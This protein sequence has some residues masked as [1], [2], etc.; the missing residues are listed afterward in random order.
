MSKTTH[1]LSLTLLLLLAFACKKG[2]GPDPVTV[3]ETPR[4]ATLDLASGVPGNIVTA[5]FNFRLDKESGEITVGGH[6]TVF[7]KL[8][9]SSAVFMVPYIPSGDVKIE[10]G[11]LAVPATAAFKVKAYTAVSAPDPVKD[12]VVTVMNEIAADASLP[13]GFGGSMATI[14]ENFVSGYQKLTAAEKA[15]VAFLFEQAMLQTP[16]TPQ[17]RQ[18]GGIGNGQRLD[19]FKAPTSIESDQQYREVMLQCAGLYVLSLSNT[20]LAANMI[21]APTGV[22]QVAGLAL[23]GTAFYTHSQANKCRLLLLKYARDTKSVESAT[24]GSYVPSIKKEGRQS[25]ASAEKEGKM[26]FEKDI[27]YEIN[28]TAMHVSLAYGSKS[29]VILSFLKELKR[30]TDRLNSAINFINNIKSWFVKS[31]NI[32]QINIG[33]PATGVE[34]ALTVKAEHVT[35]ANISNPAIILTKT[36]KDGKLI[37]KASS[38]TVTSDTEF[39]VDFVFGQPFL[40][41]SNHVTVAAL[42]SPNL[43]PHSMSLVLGNNQYGEPGEQ[44]TYPLVVKVLDV[45]GQ[46]MKDVQVEWNVTQGAGR[47]T[48]AK[49]YT[50]PDGRAQIEWTLGEDETQQVQ[51][52]VKKKDG[53]PVTGSPVVFTATTGNPWVKMISGTIWKRET[54]YLYPTS[55]YTTAQAQT[56]MKANSSECTG[57]LST[58]TYNGVVYWNIKSPMHEDVTF[59]RNFNVTSMNYACHVNTPPYENGLGNWDA[60]IDGYLKIR[61]AD[62]DFLYTKLQSIDQ[63]EIMV[64]KTVSGGQVNYERWTLK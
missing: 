24:M 26:I 21:A 12:R 2:K 57:A 16:P 47:V 20:I 43:V 10:F 33:I 64:Y 35:L 42:Y 46:P 34:S 60:S 11:V 48:A 31:P 53:T 45:R 52:V 1:L 62:F 56:M 41:L 30:V 38:T 58:M 37:I 40:G 22:T 13:E 9:D 28:V 59:H 14:R 8:G 25:E 55:Q 39:T 44:L 61:V 4:T 49:S 54:G 36:V 32:P 19:E 3:E 29:P 5:Q 15:Q 50:G 17:L 6:K 18:A 51:A 23:L 7:A 27:S 63:R